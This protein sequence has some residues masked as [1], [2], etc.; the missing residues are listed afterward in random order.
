M[1]EK[2]NSKEAA[3]SENTQKAED[4]G[5][6]CKSVNSVHSIVKDLEDV[7]SHYI[8]ET[9]PQKLIESLNLKLLV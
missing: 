9:R 4:R 2:K 5:L 1:N 7:S 6:N 3:Y 8:G